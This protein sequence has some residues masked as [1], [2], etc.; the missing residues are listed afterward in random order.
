[1][2]KWLTFALVLFL[3][4]T[5]IGIAQQPPSGALTLNQ[6]L[7]FRAVTPSDTTILK[8]TRGLQIG[9]ATACNIEV[10]GA[11]DYTGVAGTGAVTLLN[12]Q[13]GQFL[14]VSVVQV[15]NALTTCTNTFALY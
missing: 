14:P 3:A 12:V 15:M 2:T 5:G 9:N 8:P 6:V 7:Q 13:P 10:V 11:G 1:M 4:G